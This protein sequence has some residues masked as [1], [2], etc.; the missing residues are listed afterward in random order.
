MGL[1]LP[2]SQ[3]K[4]PSYHS[5]SL[6]TGRPAQTLSLAYL[7]HVL[8]TLSFPV[9]PRPADLLRTRL[10]CRPPGGLIAEQP[11]QLTPSDHT[12]AGHPVT[13]SH[14]SPAW[15]SLC[16]CPGCPR[17]LPRLSPLTSRKG[18]WE[19]LKELSPE[20]PADLNFHW[21]ASRMQGTDLSL[22]HQ[23]WASYSVLHNSRIYHLELQTKW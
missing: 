23:L 9:P 15:C 22:P 10:L 16:P 2:L 21:E 8:L 14:Y 19:I 11:E 4:P 20:G 12:S 1:Q 3:I 17:A 5:L 7:E 13:A 18:I 6:S